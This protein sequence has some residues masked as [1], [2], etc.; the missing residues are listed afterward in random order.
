MP[1]QILFSIG[2]ALIDMIPTRSS[3]EFSEVPSFKP[4][5]GGAS[6][7]VGVLAAGGY[8]QNFR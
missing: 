3:C 4:R 2:E 7:C 6:H 1:G 8:P 5:I